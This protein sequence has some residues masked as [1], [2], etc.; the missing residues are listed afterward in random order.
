MATKRLTSLDGSLSKAT[1]GATIEGDGVTAIPSNGYYLVKSVATSGSDLPAGI[2]AGY[3]VYLTTAETPATGDDVAPITFS[4][5]CNV[6]NASIDF[7]RD[8]IETTTI[9]DGVKTFSAG[10]TDLT[11]S[12]DGVAEAGNQEVLDLLNRFSDTVKLSADRTTATVSEQN[13]NIFYLQFEMNKASTAN[14]PIL[15]YFAPITILNTGNGVSQGS[16]QTF[17]SSFKVTS[18]GVNAVKP[19]IYE[20]AVV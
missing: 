20:R 15:F 16:A 3:L 19:A 2:S 7:S 14:E 17:S 8:E 6:Q 18:D 11:G 5:M 4:T 1:I 13:N 10:L 9:C 12:F